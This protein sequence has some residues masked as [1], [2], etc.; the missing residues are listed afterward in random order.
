M[1][2][3]TLTEFKEIIANGDWTRTYKP[4]VLGYEQ[5]STP[6]LNVISGIISSQESPVALGRGS[7]TS[8]FDGMEI[9]YIEEF[10]VGI[11][12]PDTFE[13]SES[14]WNTFGFIVVN[15]DDDVM[16]G[17]VVD[18]SDI[19]SHLSDKFSHVQYTGI[20]FEETIATPVQIVGVS[21][22]RERLLDIVKPEFITDI[23]AWILD[24]FDGVGENITFEEYW[25]GQYGAYYYEIPS[26]QS[27][28]GHTEL[29]EVEL[30]WEVVIAD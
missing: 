9:T 14:I 13:T 5:R 18:W 12:E 7:V 29:I 25:S 8:T 22:L 11:G 16:A 17:A 3:L 23:D 28:S 20:E 24:I 15:N 6:V 10:E 27:N 19:V 30:R 1:K 4:E 21:E 2:T 26:H